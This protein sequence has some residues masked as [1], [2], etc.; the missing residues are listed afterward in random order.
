M[1]GAPNLQRSSQRIYNSPD[2]APIVQ[3]CSGPDSYS[4]G[5]GVVLKLEI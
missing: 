1:I 4:V 2:L 3:A 5:Q